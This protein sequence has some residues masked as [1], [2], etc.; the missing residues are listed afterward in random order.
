MVFPLLIILDQDCPLCGLFKVENIKK[1]RKE[2]G[3][4]DTTVNKTD[5]IPTS[6]ELNTLVTEYQVFF[7]GLYIYSLPSCHCL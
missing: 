6:V 1:K 7:Q 4:G 2:K 3:S 5:Q